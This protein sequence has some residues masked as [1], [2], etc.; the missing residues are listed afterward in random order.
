MTRASNF[1]F[2]LFVPC[3][4][5]AILKDKEGKKGRAGGREERKEKMERKESIHE[6]QKKEI[7]V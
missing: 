1:P 5:S 7:M 2:S 3:L 6:S 4:F